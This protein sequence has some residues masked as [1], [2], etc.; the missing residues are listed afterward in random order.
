M[1]LLQQHGAQP[2]KQPKYVPV[3]IDRAFTGLYTQRAVLHDPSDIYTSRYYGGRPDALWMGLNIELTNRLTLQRRPGLTLFST[4]TYSTPP[5]RSFPFQ[6]QDGTIRVIIDTGTSGNLSLTQATLSGLNTIYTGT[7]PAGAGNAYVGLFFQI[8]GFTNSGNN[9]TFLCVASTATTLTL[10]NAV[11]VNETHAGLAITSGGV[12]WDQQ[13]GSAVLLFGKSFGAGQTYFTAVA[14]VLYMGDG[15]DTKKYA[16]SNSNATVTPQTSP[17]PSTT[18]NTVWNWGGAAPVNP[19]G[20]TVTSSGSA[21]GTWF[22]STWFS[23]MGLIVDPNGNVQQLHAIVNPSTVVGSVGVI[24]SSSAGGPTWNQ[25]PGLTTTD[26]TVT[27]R[28]LSL[29]VPWAPHMNVISETQAFSSNTA[30]CIVYDQTTGCFFVNFNSS[31][32]GITSAFNPFHYSAATAPNPGTVVP[33]DSSVTWLCLGNIHSIPNGYCQGLWK[34]NQVIAA[35]PPSIRLIEPFT[36]PQPGYP[37]PPGAMYLQENTT[38][39]T[40]ASS[41]TIFGTSSS[42]GQI[43]KEPVA[44]D[45]SQLEWL[46]VTAANNGTG[47]WQANTSYVGWSSP[48][49]SGFGVVKDNNGSLWVASVGGTSAAALSGGSDPFAAAGLYWQAG[50]AYS[51]GTIIIDSNSNRQLV[52]VAGTSGGV[53]PTWNRN[54]GQNTTDNTVTWKNLGSAYGYGPIT[55]GANGLQWFNVGRTAS[56][57]ANQKY[58]LPNQGFF[59]PSSTPLGGADISDGT[60]VEYVVQT[61]LSGV[62]S[63]TWNTSSSPGSNETYDPSPAAAGGVV[64]YNNGVFNQNS[65]SWTKS[66]TWAYSYKARSLT[67]F[68]SVASGLPLA[69]PAPPPGQPFNGILPPPSGAQTNTITTASPAVTKSG[70]N[71]GSVVTLYGNYSSD[72]QFDTIIIWRDPDGIVTSTS[73]PVG[74]L[75]L[76]E[77]PNIPS[78]AGTKKYTVN[79]V[80]YDWSFQ[81]FLPDTPTATFPGL[82]PL[83]IAP[84]NHQNDPPPSSFRPM[85]YN[86][87]RIWGSY[88]LQVNFSGGPDVTTGN[89]NEAFLLSDELPFLAPAQKLVRTPQG[90]I[91]MTTDSIELI[92]GGPQTLS[93]YT[94]QLSS[95][96]GLLSFNASDVFAGETFFFSSD[97]QFYILSPS[98]SVSNFGF[99]LG[100]QFANLPSSGI[101]DT[102]WD[103]SK[104]YVAVHQSGI[105]NC[106]IVSDGVTGWYR[107][108][109]RQVPGAAQG[110]EP[111][112]SPFAAITNGCQMVQSVEYTPGK[113][114]L[115]V[116]ST[117]P[118][119]S[120][121]KR[122]LG[123]YTDNG[124]QYDAFFL[125]GSIVLAHPGQL[126]LLKFLEGDFSGNG[127][128]PAISYLLN[129]I[130]GTFVP[131]L[132]AP[133]FDPPSI[134]GQRFSPTSYSPNRYY[135]ASNAKL[136]RCRHLQIRVDYGLSPNGDEVYDLT[137]YGR[138][139]SEF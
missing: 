92:A 103:P 137:I 93:F 91:V 32:T 82:N 113:K 22:A 28:N 99:P 96:M 38:S 84:I 111:I 60:N 27:W 85:V 130:S 65:L 16:P 97:N 138:I 90:L 116:G 118:A 29:I 70:A 11:G 101:L 139:L 7:F 12:Y 83:I 18:S 34:P 20:V 26:N 112:W 50:H 21:A 114:S 87:Q 77:I 75:E 19:L 67:D 30:P 128:Q 88:L 89:P 129:E 2:Q 40:T 94:V 4:F 104:V 80:F 33:E 17:Q 107:L 24:G 41:G 95:G 136:A 79:G 55:D 1:N 69:I 43:I 10:A 57:T 109:P 23:T 122:T 63:P 106:I 49:S 5:L 64:W 9:G 125:M 127:F 132:A 86:F 51:T 124:T 100:D 126:A 135:F 3:F 110:P 121:S 61:G 66:H 123:V 73:N 45:G 52:I 15:I 131:F 44:T 6:L 108:N 120:I 134:Y 119:K 105:D 71:A 62:A 72:P 133:I 48:T 115:L 39:G 31:P 74:M 102:T 54:Q 117:L 8:T 36:L 13:N 78:Q 58:Y 98:L 47:L 14:G 35:P 37:L 81:D 46:C 53:A 56:W 25:T 42:A 76:T 59:S 68:F